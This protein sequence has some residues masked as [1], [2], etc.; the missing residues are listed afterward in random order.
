MNRAAM[1]LVEIDRRQLLGFL[2]PQR[3]TQ[4]TTESPRRR[5]RQLKASVDCGI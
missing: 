5:Q 4:S 1:R 2:N 3:M